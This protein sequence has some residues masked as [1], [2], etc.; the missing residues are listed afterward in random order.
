MFA[1]FILPLAVW[2]DFICLYVALNV[3]YL[4]VMV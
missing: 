1:G 3:V 2:H 4:L